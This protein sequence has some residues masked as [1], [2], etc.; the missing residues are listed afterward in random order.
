MCVC[1]CVCACGCVFW[2]HFFIN[3]NFVEHNGHFLS[4]YFLFDPIRQ[5]ERINKEICRQKMS[6]I[7]NEICIYIYIYIL[8]ERGGE[9][10]RESMYV[11][12]V[13]V[14]FP[15]SHSSVC[16][17]LCVCAFTKPSTTTSKRQM[18]NF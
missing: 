1:V 10:E 2:Q 13:F 11:Y 9:R 12:V 17:C 15:F 4:I 16:A 6:I 8:R 18:I 5:Y 14:I 3:T 7:F